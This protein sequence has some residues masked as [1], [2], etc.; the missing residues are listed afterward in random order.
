MYAL[1]KLT[2]FVVS[3]LAITSALAAPVEPTSSSNLAARAPYDV[4]NGSV[5]DTSTPPT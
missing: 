1:N 3:A 2:A 5:S 4:H